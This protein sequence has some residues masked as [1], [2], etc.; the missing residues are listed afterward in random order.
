MPFFA[1]DALAAGTDVSERGLAP[2]NVRLACDARA[3]SEGLGVATGREVLVPIAGLGV[4]EG[5]EAGRL[6]FLEAG[7]P[8]SCEPTTGRLAGRTAPTDLEGMAGLC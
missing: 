4:T 1:E 7:R 6:A 3:P 2:A 8:P 5:R